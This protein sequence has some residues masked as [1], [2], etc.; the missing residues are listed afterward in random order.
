M[1]EESRKKN[2]MYLFLPNSNVLK[3]GPLVPILKVV[4]MM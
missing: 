2:C 3:H 1:N 4:L